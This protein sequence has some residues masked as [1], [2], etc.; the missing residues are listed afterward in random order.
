MTLRPDQRERLAFLARVTRKECAHLRI[1]NERLFAKPLTLSD[2]ARLESDPD[3][4]ERVEAFVGRFARLQDTI[5]DKLLPALLLAV[6]ERLG[7]FVDNL[8]RAE[9][10]GWLESAEDWLVMR[11]LRNQMVHEYIEDPHILIDALTTGNAFV[12][13]LISVGERMVSEAERRIQPGT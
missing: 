5:G 7:P 9:R 2:I 6:G 4:A 8:D 1:T 3:L 10:L 13:A 12:P 11:Q